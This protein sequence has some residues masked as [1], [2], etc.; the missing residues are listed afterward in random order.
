V[1]SKLDHDVN[2]LISVADKVH[3]EEEVFL[4]SVDEHL[5]VN[6]HIRH[7]VLCNKVDVT[8]GKPFNT[9]LSDSG[10]K[11]NSTR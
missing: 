4:S 10:L 3:W 5:V 9:S 6:N 7:P 1:S 2:T 8:V 11:H